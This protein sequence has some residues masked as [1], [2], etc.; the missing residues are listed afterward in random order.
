MKHSDLKKKALNRAEVRAEYEALEP[1][2]ELLR[3]MLRARTSAGLTQAEVAKRMGTQAPAVT[4]L[5]SALSSGTHSPSI[6]TLKRYAGAVGCDL[7]LKFV[8]SA[9]PNKAL[10]PTSLPSLRSGKA[11]A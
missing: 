7:Q 8:P 11:V 2:F 3:Q 6:Q 1:E 4:R 9:R 10:K 5:E